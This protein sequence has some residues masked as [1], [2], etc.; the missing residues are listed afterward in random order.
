MHAARPGSSAQTEL[1]L[2]NARCEMLGRMTI[3][4]VPAHMA[5]TQ[6]HVIAASE[7]SVLVWEITAGA[8]SYS[9]A[10]PAV[11]SL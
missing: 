4:W 2:S 8:F 6:T 3:P 7:G 9:I 5:A 11:Q 1:T 10:T